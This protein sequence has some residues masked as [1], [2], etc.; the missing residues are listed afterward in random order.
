MVGMP[1]FSGSLTVNLIDPIL[2]PFGF[3]EQHRDQHHGGDR[4]GDNDIDDGEHDK[5]DEELRF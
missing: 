5:V 2:E 4:N 3:L 1:I